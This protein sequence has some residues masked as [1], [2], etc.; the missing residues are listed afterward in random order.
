HP[1]AGTRRR[2][3]G[4]QRRLRP[5]ILDVLEDDRRIEDRDLAVEECGH[6][7]PRARGGEGRVGTE[8]VGQLRLER[9]ALLE[10]RDLHLLRVRREG[11]L[12][13]LHHAW[14]ESTPDRPV[15]A[16]PLTSADGGLGRGV[17]RGRGSRTS[18]RWPRRRTGRGG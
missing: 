1:H 10:E 14:T 12:V 5:A 15:P 2:R 9:N 4:Q 13:E 7:A 6:L 16:G 18:S 11:M 3:L 8:Q 17:T